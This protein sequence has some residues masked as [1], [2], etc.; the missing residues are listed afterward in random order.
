MIKENLNSMGHIRIV[1]VIKSMGDWIAG[2]IFI[3]SVF[4][5]DKANLHICVGNGLC[6]ALCVADIVYMRFMNNKKR[7]IQICGFSYKV[8]VVLK[9][10]L[11]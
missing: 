7:N 4:F 6:Q 5:S 2:S 1:I 3:Q 10:G 11:L 9:S 8:D